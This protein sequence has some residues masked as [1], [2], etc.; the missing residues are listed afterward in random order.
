MSLLNNMIKRPPIGLLGNVPMP[1]MKPQNLRTP[2]N[3]NMMPSQNMMPAPPMPLARPQNLPTPNLLTAP[4][5]NFGFGKNFDDPMTQGI[6]GA[7]IGLLDAGGYSTTP[8]TFGQNLAQGMKMGMGAYNS[9]RDKANK[10]NLQVV[11]GSLI[12]TSDPK[13]PKVVYEGNKSKPKTSLLGGG[14]YVA[15]TA[16]DGSVTYGK[17]GLY[18]TIIE[19]EKRAKAEKLSSSKLSG[20]LQK[21]ET[22]DIFALETAKNIMS[23]IDK[24]D[25]LITDGKLEFGLIDTLGDYTLGFFGGQGEEERNSSQFKSF[26]EKLRN[27]SLKLAKGIQTDADA[28]RVMKE[29]FNAFDSNDNETIQQKLREIKKINERSIAI[30]KKSIVNRRDGQNVKPFDFSTLGNITTP[31]SNS[32]PDIKFTIKGNK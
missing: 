22:D 9:A 29:L 4:T 25:Q 3:Q 2:S 6:L 5:N 15:V 27:D 19:D 10:N 30:R 18:D 24:F 11:G 20:T 21:A 14:K 13:N 12:D 32:T 23:D 1:M 31:D 7:S 26:I 16:P 28:D 8:R 17:S